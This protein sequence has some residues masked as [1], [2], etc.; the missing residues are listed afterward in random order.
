MPV[1]NQVVELIKSL[2]R[3]TILVCVVE[4]Q[5]SDLVGLLSLAEAICLQRSSEH[6]SHGDGTDPNDIWAEV[7]GPS[8]EGQGQFQEKYVLVSSSTG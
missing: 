4:T 8:T 2:E 5:I 1:P 3:G 6:D 7:R